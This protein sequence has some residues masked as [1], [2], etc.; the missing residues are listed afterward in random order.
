MA[1]VTSVS[2]TSMANITP[3][4]GELNMAEIAPAAPQPINYV[5]FL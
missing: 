3:A 4:I 5:L 2:N 1:I